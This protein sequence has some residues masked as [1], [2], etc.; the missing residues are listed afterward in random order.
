MTHPLPIRPPDRFTRYQQWR[1]YAE[2]A[3]WVLFFFVHGAANGWLS[4]IE[5]GWSGLRNVYLKTWQI[6]ALPGFASLALLALAPAVIAFERRLPL[7]WGLLRKNLPWHLLATVVY[8]IAHVLLA[9]M[10]IK[11]AYRSQGEELLIPSLSRAIFFAYLKDLRIYFVVIV[12]LSFYRL[13]MLRWQGEARLLEVPDE[14]PPVEPVERPQRFLVRKLG[15]DFLLPAADIEWI[16]AWGNYVNLR[17]RG[18]DYPLRSTMSA[19]EG[20]LDPRRFI[21]VHRSYFV[22]LDHL[23]RLEP[24]ES[25]DARAAM[26]DGSEVPVSRRYLEALRKASTA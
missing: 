15:K 7:R 24:L 18:H 9:V 25:G 12:I 22:N 14:G 8:C 19:I 16:Q 23:L 5:L 20:R 4:W 11:L 17:V 1:P 13:L 26:S 3:F 2:P 10:L 6:F 21:R